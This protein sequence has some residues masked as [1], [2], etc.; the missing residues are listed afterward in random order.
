MSRSHL[1]EGFFLSLN[2]LSHLISAQ[3]SPSWV[4]LIVL[5]CHMLIVQLPGLALGGVWGVRE[6]AG[7][8]LAVSNTRLRIN[9][10]LN[11]VTR[12]GT[13]IGNSAGVLGTYPALPALFAYL[14]VFPTAI[15]YSTCIQR[16]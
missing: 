5:F 2:S 11:S 14:I 8:P 7:R 12:R 16:N 13:F 10:I 4:T 1:H 9:S 3:H 6:G 15:N